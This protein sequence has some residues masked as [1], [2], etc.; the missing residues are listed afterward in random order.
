[1]N[2]MD[3]LQAMFA[4]MMDSLKFVDAGEIPDIDLYM[5]QVTTFMN[6]HLSAFAR[7]PE[8]DKILTKTMINNYAKSDLLVP[9][10]RKYGIDHMILLLFIYYLK[11]FLSINDVARILAPLRSEYAKTPV[12]K[13]GKTTPSAPESGLSI[14]DIYERI[15]A[16]IG[17]HKDEITGEINR[18]FEC[19]KGTFTDVPERER[20]KLQKVTL[21][22]YLR[23]AESKTAGGMFSHGRPGPDPGR[24][25]FRKDARHHTPHCLSSGGMR[26]Q[27][28]EHPRNYLY[29]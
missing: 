3:E 2:Q 11:N 7:D 24:C 17:K 15:Y 8:N 19:A 26:C 25:G 10:V 29:E 1:M 13:K 12:V 5:D 4:D 18:E 27:S 6:Q 28:V 16:G 20:G 9:P 14:R 21:N 22:E 23:Y